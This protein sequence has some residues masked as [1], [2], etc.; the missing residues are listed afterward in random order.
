MK[1]WKDSG[2]LFTSVLGAPLHERNVS[3]MFHALCDRAK[4]PSIRFHDTRHSC[5]TL[6]HA[7]HASPFIIQ[8]VLGHSQ[9]S[10]TR[11]YTHVDAEVAKA[12]ITDLDSMFETT[13]DKRKAE[14]ERQRAA[15]QHPLPLQPIQ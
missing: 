5:G 4:V 6:L 3:V 13:R 1:N 2:Y 10:T 8:T 9:L 12:A 15:A 11:R 14:E 7:Q